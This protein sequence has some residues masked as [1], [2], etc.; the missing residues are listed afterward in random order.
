MTWLDILI[1]LPLLIGLV[2]GIKRGLII[3][4]TNL[5][6]I[7]AGVVCARLLSAPVAA[8]I[9]QQFTWPEAVCSVVAYTLLFLIS[10]IL[11]YLLGKL[12]TKLF[13]AV[14]LGWLNRLLGGVFGLAK[15]AIIVL[16]VVLCV[17]QLD[18]QFQFLQEDLKEESVVYKAVIPLSENT[19]YTMKEQINDATS[20][21]NEQ[22]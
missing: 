4:L 1:L 5:I 7:I 6:S 2:I 21:K 13:K 12:L 14:K 22:E 3:E 18:T 20:Q 19:W 17:H 16:F 15:Y 11:L 10:T 9:A 8:W